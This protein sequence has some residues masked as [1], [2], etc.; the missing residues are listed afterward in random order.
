[1]K[2]Y[3]FHINQCESVNS[4]QRCATDIGW[5]SSVHVKYVKGDTAT[6][7]LT[8]VTDW[9]ARVMPML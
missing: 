1:M 4:V 7:A 3:Q 9:I 5:C 8:L 6:A 2:P